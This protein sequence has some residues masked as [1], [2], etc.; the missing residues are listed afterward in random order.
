MQLQDGTSGENDM[1]KPRANPLVDSGKP[2]FFK[3]AN[4]EELGVSAP[5]IRLG[6][7]VRL[8]VRSLSVMQ[9]EALVSSAGTGTV[10][11]LASDE[12]A[13]LDGLDAAPC[14]LSFLT[15][16]MV[17]SYVNEILALARQRNLT[18]N[19][20]RLVQDNYYTMKGSARTGTMTG[21]A[22]NVELAVQIDSDAVRNTLETL[23]VD[24]VAASPLNGL[25]RG[26]KESLFTL[27]HNGEEIATARALA[28]GS[29][30][31]PDPGDH[32]DTTRPTDDDWSG[33]LRKGGLTP[34]SKE[35][36]TFAGDSLREEQDRV[37]HV[38]GICTLRDDGVKQVEA[39]LFN[40]HGSIFHL[41]CDEA[42]ENGGKGLAPDAAS[43]IS[44]GIGFCFM[45]QF[46]RYAKI[47]K[48][49]LQEYR[50]LQDTHF[51]L[52]GASGGTGKA[53]SAD[54]VET[55][56]YLVTGE[57]D[58]FASEAL[59]MSEQTCFLHAFCRT[60]LKTRVTIEAFDKG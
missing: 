17:C 26:A 60:D 7:A 16:G 11:R 45:T 36:V 58:A 54:P 29:P 2:L 49:D 31:Q 23:V 21:G 48:K 30:A 4:P 37:L 43:Y 19:K 14:P 57:D 55:H 12:G 44:A 42:P 15:T 53:G 38:R 3:V 9:K 40:P 5:A 28:L 52:G 47:M 1:T 8:C 33:L 18:I 50:I 46:G 22:K 27:S 51:S 32:F 10:W 20:L 41:L 6:E 56:V 39:Q 24:A 35:T 25:M 34:K 59:D 13:Y